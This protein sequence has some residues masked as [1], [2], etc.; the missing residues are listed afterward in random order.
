MCCLWASCVNRVRTDFKSA[1]SG[2]KAGKP[3]QLDHVTDA[4]GD[5]GVQDLKNQ[6]AG[7]YVYNSLGQLIKNNSEGISYKYNASG[8]VTEIKKSNIPLLKLFFNDKSHRVR[9]EVFDTHGSLSNTQYYVRDAAGS[10]LAIYNNQTQIELP[11][12]GASRL[13]V[14]FKQH[15]STAYQ[16]TDHLGNVRAVVTK[17]GDI[18]SSTD[19]YP[20]GMPMP[21]RNTVDANGYRYAF[22]GQEKD[23]ET[24]KEAFQLRLW[25]SRIGRWLTT[26]PMGQYS[27]PYIGMGNDPVN[28]IDSDGGWKTKWGRFWGWAGGGFKG[29][30]IGDG[31]GSDPNKNYGLQFSEITSTFDINGGYGHASTLS[32]AYDSDGITMNTLDSWDREILNNPARMDR[33]SGFLPSAS[34]RTRLNAGKKEDFHEVISGVMQ[35]EIG[36]VYQVQKELGLYGSGIYGSRGTNILGKANGVS[37]SNNIQARFPGFE[38]VAMKAGKYLN[39]NSKLQTH[40]IGK[41][42]KVFDYGRVN[43]KAIEIHYYLHKTSG[44]VANAKI[45][46]TSKLRRIVK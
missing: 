9:K 21:N 7:N 38:S 3:N 30:F 23:P 13:G 4:V 39:M 40:V 24:G 44:R 5:A 45:K 27:S 18:S 31:M 10:V 25:D 8:L 41:W 22:Q 11:I 19:Y 20:F 12:Y 35:Q 2:Y 28:G 1:R 29:V 14:F 36:A 46:N 37:V 15:N 16:L 32:F 42:I 33:L 17:N 34:L 6:A 26:D 43:G